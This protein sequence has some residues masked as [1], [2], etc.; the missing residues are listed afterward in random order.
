MVLHDPVALLSGE[1]SRCE[2]IVCWSGLAKLFIFRQ[3]ET[4]NRSNKWNSRRAPKILL[5]DDPN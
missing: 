2:S 3:P 4:L 1:F 5:I